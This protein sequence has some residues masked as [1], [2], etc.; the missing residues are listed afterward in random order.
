MT[1]VTYAPAV[2][3]LFTRNCG[4]RTNIKKQNVAVATE[5]LRLLHQPEAASEFMN[6]LWGPWPHR[7]VFKKL[8][9]P[10]PHA[11]NA[12]TGRAVHSAMTKRLPTEPS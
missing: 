11:N 5:Y 2:T 10:L 8:T 1:E 6:R 4:H 12:K 9:A 3:S 7:A